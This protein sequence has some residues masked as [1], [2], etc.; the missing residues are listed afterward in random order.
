MESAWILYILVFLA[1]G[2]PDLELRK[3]PTL[4]E[5]ESAS[6]RVTEELAQEYDMTGARI[7]CI[8]YERRD[9]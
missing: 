7:Y 6:V 3:Y 8:P 4:E 2:Q 1:N 5:C 9:K